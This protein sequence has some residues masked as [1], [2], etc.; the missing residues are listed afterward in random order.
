M[1][2]V[3]EH[4]SLYLKSISSQTIN[5]SESTK[6]TRKILSGKYNSHCRE[7]KLPGAVYFGARM[8]RECLDV[9]HLGDFSPITVI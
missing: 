9:H 8:F 7:D 2:G 6:L 1:A 3:G 4:Q 5:N